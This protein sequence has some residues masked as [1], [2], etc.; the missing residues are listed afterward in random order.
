MTAEEKVAHVT[1]K[2]DPEAAI[3]AICAPSSL[4]LG[5]IAALERIKSPLLL[6]KTSDSL[7]NIIGCYVA[8]AP[9]V[10]DVLKQYREGSLESAALDWVERFKN[11][12]DYVKFLAAVLDAISA[13][14][15]MLP[16]AAKENNPDGSSKKETASETASSPN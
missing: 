9:S 7:D 15:S 11:P 8:T 13:F 10:A 12:T 2:Q 1:Q 4:T 6:G 5:H 16:R 3:S 14:W